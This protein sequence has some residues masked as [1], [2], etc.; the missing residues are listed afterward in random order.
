MEPYH[1]PPAHPTAGYPTAPAY[2]SYPAA[3]DY[4]ASYPVG[5]EG[6]NNNND[7]DNYSDDAPQNA[8]AASAR[9]E[10]CCGRVFAAH[11][12]SEVATS[13][14]ACVPWWLMSLTRGA[15]AC[16]LLVLG[17]ILNIRSQ[18]A[19]ASFFV[20]FGLSATF[21]LL[22][23]S[24]PVYARG[25]RF[26]SRVF[27]TAIGIFHTFFAAIAA[28]HLVD[29]VARL[30]LPA[31]YSHWGGPIS[32]IQILA[33][34]VPVALYLVDVLVIQASI[35]LKYRYAAA[36]FVLYFLMWTAFYFVLENSGKARRK[37]KSSIAVWAV[38]SIAYL[39]MSQVV[40]AVSRISFCCF[41][42]TRGDSD[43]NAPPV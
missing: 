37:S 32:G 29:L 18:F 16:G 33:V 36:A 25:K 7:N 21:L 22:A 30:A 28:F 3:D 6:V 39:I 5:D 41:K 10:R 42:N 38:I 13:G 20:V 19:G 40:A 15:S 17:V 2:P 12:L 11:T 26:N 4:P 14:Y 1:A 27:P 8:A 24:G 9:R 43:S 34:V 31:R 35:R 23:L